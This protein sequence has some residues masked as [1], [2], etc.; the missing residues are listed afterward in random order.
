ME[1]VPV[2]ELAMCLQLRSSRL[3]GGEGLAGVLP[4]IHSSRPKQGPLTEWLA[5]PTGLPNPHGPPGNEGK[6]ELDFSHAPPDR[7]ATWLSL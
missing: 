4:A 1:T 7:Q 5:L 2:L 6:R 3:A